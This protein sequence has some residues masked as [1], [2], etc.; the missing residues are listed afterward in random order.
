MPD[1]KDAVDALKRV[2]ENQR[3]QQD[4]MRELSQQLATE[5]EQEARRQ[6]QEGAK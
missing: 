5:R 3:V 2:V 1:A 4:T 6:Q